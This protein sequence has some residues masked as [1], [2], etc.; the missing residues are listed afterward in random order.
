MI[1]VNFTKSKSFAN[2]SVTERGTVQGSSVKPMQRSDCFPPYRAHFKPGS[3]SQVADDDERNEHT[4][5]AIM[6]K[7]MRKILT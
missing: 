5:T 6:T 2:N 3:T 1:I 4:T 7:I